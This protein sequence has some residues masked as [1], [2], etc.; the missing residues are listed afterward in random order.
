MLPTALRTFNVQDTGVKLL[1]AFSHVQRG[2]IVSIAKG[3]H[4]RSR[5]GERRSL[6][7]LGILR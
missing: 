1:E 4:G 2:C 5:F 7:H 3:L 6:A